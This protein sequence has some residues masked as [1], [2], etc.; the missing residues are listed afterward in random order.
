M[1][2]LYIRVIYD[3]IEFAEGLDRATGICYPLN[4]MRISHGCKKLTVSYEDLGSEFSLK[5][6]LPPS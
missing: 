3:T 5:I 2:L 4:F 1:I 6:A